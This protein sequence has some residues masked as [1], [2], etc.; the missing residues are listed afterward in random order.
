[1]GVVSNLDLLDPLESVKPRYM[2][3][4]STGVPYKI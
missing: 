4:E 3:K 1:M 2:Q